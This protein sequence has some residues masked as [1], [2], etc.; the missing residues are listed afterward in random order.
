MIP[1]LSY[2]K[3]RSMTDI[4]SGSGP[5]EVS[6]KQMINARADVNQLVP[7]K[8]QWAYDKYQAGCANTWM[9]QEVSMQADLDLWKSRDGLTDDER[10]LVLRNLSFFSTAESLIANN[11]VL[12][13][14]RLITNPECRMYLLR[15][16]FEEGVHSDTFAYICE[17]LGLEDM[18]VF[19]GYRE[20]PS[21]TA[22][23]A[24][25]LQYTRSLEDPSFTTENDEDAQ[26]FLRDLIAFYV[27]FEGT[28]FYPG[29]AQILSLGRRNKMTGIAEQYQYIMRDESIHVNFGIDAINQIKAENPQLWN[30]EFQGE[31]RDMMLRAVELEDEYTDDTLPRG[32]VGINA[33]QMKQYTRFIADRRLGQLGLSPLFNVVDSP[34]P[35]MSEVT[36]LQKEK[37]FFETRVTEYQSGG[38][39][40]W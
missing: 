32:I 30:D 22:K 19:N 28:W 5:V 14:Y 40:E 38:G 9:P 8:Y 12:S 34:F 25:A 27:I 23:D 33:D 37:N 18:N 17:S 39:L 36:D 11:I 4:A 35:W 31:V 3:R 26:K 10:H 20:I 1:P 13:I 24:W 29:F 21:I 16:A 15:Q 2:L 6:D 7:I